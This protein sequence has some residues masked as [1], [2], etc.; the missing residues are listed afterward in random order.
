MNLD[1][2]NANQKEAVKTVNGPLLVLAGAGSGKTRVLTTRVVYLIE[3]IGISPENILAITFTN[4]AAKEMKDRI[5]K[6]LGPIAYKIQI[7]TFHSFGLLIMK[8]HYDVLGYKK[9]FTI[10]DSDDTL[11]LI[12]KIMK[13]NGVDPKQYNPKAIRNHISGAKNELLTPDKY[14]EYAASEFEKEVVFIYRL[15]Q[16]R[17]KT[18]NSLDFDDLLML[19]IILLKN[20]P[21]ILKEYQERFQYILVDE[22]QDTNEAQY[23]MVKMISAKYKNVCV[24]GDNDQSIYSWRGSNYRNILNLK[25]I[26]KILK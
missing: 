3:E 23:I 5:F 2:L 22:Y 6:L 7:S 24:V 16:D 8:E 25:R 10:L 11:T 18:N 13:E 9:N 14:E 19:P 12:K 15:Y 21:H 20:N 26:I 1:T 4:K 17:L